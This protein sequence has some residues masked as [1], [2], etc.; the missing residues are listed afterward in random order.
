MIIIWG[1]LPKKKE[2]QLQYIE[3]GKLAQLR[4]WKNGLTFL[5]ENMYPSTVAQDRCTGLT[6]VPGPPGLLLTARTGPGTHSP[7]KNA[8]PY[9]S[10]HP[11][12]H[13]TL[14]CCAPAGLLVCSWVSK[15][16][17]FS[18]CLFPEAD[19]TL[20]VSRPFF[21]PILTR[22]ESLNFSMH[23]HLKTC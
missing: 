10:D 14:T 22:A 19:P 20:L 4:S 5:K 16:P 18:A 17:V 13:H 8:R 11:Y 15:A 2:P 6:T 3:E 21:T 9:Q 1:A 23:S 12:P 7:M